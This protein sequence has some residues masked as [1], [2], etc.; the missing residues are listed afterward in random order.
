MRTSETPS[1]GLPAEPRAG[2][3]STTLQ[4]WL[5]SI[6]IAVLFGGAFMLFSLW[7]VPDVL[8]YYG[9]FVSNDIWQSI[10]GARYVWHGALGY[11]YEGTR[12]YALPLSFIFLAPA[13][14]IIDH[15]GLV[16]GSPFPLPMPSAWLVAAP[17]SLLFGIFFL[18][19]IRNLAR[20]LGIER[21]LWVIQ[22][23]GALV[24]LLPCYYWGHPEDVLA[25]TFVVYGARRFLRANHT[26]AAIFLSLA[27]SSKQW[28]VVLIPFLLVGTPAG[29]RLRGLVAATAL[30][31]AFTLFVVGTDPSS[32]IPAL[33]SPVNL[34]IHAPGHISFYATWLGSRTSQVSRTIGTLLAF[35]LAWPL[36]KVTGPARWLG[37]A[38]LILLV[39]PFAE[40]ISY[41][42]Y[43]SPAMVMAGL[44]SLAAHKRVRVTDWLAPLG[45]VVWAL[46]RSNYA[47][48]GWWWAGEML[49]LAITAGQVCANLG[50]LPASWGLR[51]VSVKYAGARPILNSMMTTSGSGDS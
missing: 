51:S 47:T 1:R 10:D 2:S 28:A 50:F 46:P 19:A 43:W 44:V 4:D 34:G 49:L 48:N 33:F 21:R 8:G 26:A 45:V 25:I 13:A 11:V 30:P 27:I 37:A 14:G 40:A 29:H 9:W 18:H 17:Y 36:R 23:L 6:A 15:F 35:L 12:S 20:D 38:G 39:R 31:G 32:A 42:Y 7:F 24:V 16:E 5:S 41:S 22:I 3:V